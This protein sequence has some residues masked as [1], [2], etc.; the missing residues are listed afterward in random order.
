MLLIT[1]YLISPKIDLPNSIHKL[2]RNYYVLYGRKLDQYFC[3][4]YDKTLFYKYKPGDCLVK[5]LEFETHLEINSFGTRDLEKNLK[6]ENNVIF[7]G[8]S[9]TVGWGIPI[10]KRFSDIVSSVPGFNSINLGV[11]SYGTAREMIILKEYLE[12]NKEFK[13]NIKNIV[14]QYE[15]NDLEE[16]QS[17]FENQNILKISS[18]EK[19]Q[20]VRNHNINKTK[21][22]FGKGSHFLYVEL[23]KIFQNEILPKITNA[24]SRKQHPNVEENNQNSVKYLINI[25]KNNADILE[26]KKII[27]FGFHTY[28]GFHQLFESELKKITLPFEI[29]IIE[30]NNELILQKEFD[31]YKIDKHLNIEGH[32]KLAKYILDILR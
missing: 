25:L 1:S 20:E 23:K 5:N 9:H 7:L 32:Q 8:D 19:F 4:E 2:I 24:K 14:I 18:E 21:Y 31:Y 28:S 10:G 30:V 12:L 16:N 15:L 26:G 11:A 6:R 13:D 22:Y 29:K 27:I 17:Y 3:G